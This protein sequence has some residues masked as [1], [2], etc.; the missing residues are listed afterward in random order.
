M[1]LFK[2]TSLNQT[3]RPTTCALYNA[4]WF[5]AGMGKKLASLLTNYLKEVK[6]GMPQ[7]KTT[8]QV[9]EYPADVAA[10]SF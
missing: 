3:H 6:A 2:E 1:T 5:P 10:R 8:Y 9:V 4:A 7:D